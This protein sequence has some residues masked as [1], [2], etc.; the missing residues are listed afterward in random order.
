M[1]ASS[2]IS[3]GAGGAVGGFCRPLVVIGWVID[4]AASVA[5]VCSP[6][7]FLYFFPLPQAQGSFLPIFRALTPDWAP[8]GA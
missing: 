6:Q 2:A 7:H 4:R 1:A 8:V 5:G 3:V